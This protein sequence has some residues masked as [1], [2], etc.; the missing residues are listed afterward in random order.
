[1]LS[2]LK[3][4]NLKNRDWSTE[5]DHLLLELIKSNEYGQNNK[6]KWANI[7]QS[8]NQKI[9]SKNNFRLGK[10]CRERFFNH[11]NPRLRKGDWSNQ[12]D[13]ILLT[14]YL[15]FHKRWSKINSYLE[16]RNDNSVKNHF[17]KLMKTNNLI[18]KHRKQ[19]SDDKIQQLIEKLMTMNDNHSQSKNPFKI[20]IK[21]QHNLQFSSNS[22]D[23]YFLEDRLNESLNLVITTPYF[24][25]DEK[26]KLKDHS[27]DFE[28]ENCSDSNNN[29]KNTEE[30]FL[31]FSPNQRTHNFPQCFDNNA[32]EQN[33]HEI[34]ESSKNK[35]K[36]NCEIL[37]NG[38]TE[39]LED[40]KKLKKI[41]AKS[42]TNEKTGEMF[43]LERIFSEIEKINIYERKTFF[44]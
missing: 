7:S 17:Y 26:P 15:K 32:H 29:Q 38:Q 8:F 13:V 33:I 40:K 42:P 1:M 9:S 19:I 31:F 5:E 24:T 34:I 25:M 30:D 2:C 14:N 4:E 27:S 22:N 41:L 18:E 43:F 39:N 3:N 11:L 44:F 6:F 23:S 28:E 16:G 35:K 21:P 20:E 10:H 36:W 37:K 12:E